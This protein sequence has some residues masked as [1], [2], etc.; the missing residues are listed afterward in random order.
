MVL[1][2]AS[3]FSQ[4]WNDATLKAALTLPVRRFRDSMR[5]S[6]VE[7]SPGVYAFDKPTSR[8]PALLD[9]S[10]ARL[11]LT[12]NW[13]NPH[14]DEGKTPHTAEALAAFGRFAAET[15]KR[16]PAVDTVEI[17]NEINGS[18]FVSGPVKDGG[19]V[20]RARYHL[21]MVRAARDAVRQVRPDVRVLGGATH[22]LP[23]GFLWNLLAAP[24]ADA[25]EG[26]AVHPYT[27]PIDQL[28]AQFAVLRRD[29]RTA[30]LPVHVTEFGS[31]NPQTAA[32]D[33]VRGYAVLS[34]L[35]VAEMDWYPL[36]ERGDGMVPLL[37]RDQSLTA[38]G[39]A[40]RFVQERLASR[41]ATSRNL[42][43]FT[44]L[45]AFG[46]NT[47][48]LW[49]APRVLTVGRDVTA[50]DATGSR[51]DSKALMINA[52]KVIILTS[53]SP[54]VAGGNVAFG[55]QDL[56]ADSFHQFDYAANDRSNGFERFI[57]IGGRALPFEVLPGQQRGGVPWT[58]YLGHTRFPRLRLHAETML[59]ALPQPDG[60]I[61]H[62]YIARRSQRLRL[63][64][65]FNA[66]DHGKGGIRVIVSQS[67][68]VLSDQTGSTEVRLD[69]TVTVAGGEALTIAVRGAPK[70]NAVEYRLKISD[71][72]KCQIQP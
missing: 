49:G 44:L 26:L 22:S 14:Y 58:P 9:A 39:L 24:G 54:L 11:T 48:V 66:P 1:G 29:R 19:L 55:C 62:R 69:E 36:N 70:G 17:G 46:P 8:Y 40:F 7:R 12:L 23:A 61:V 28:P 52:D 45:R 35:G 20:L 38:A 21:A 65:E 53:N 4:G 31:Q 50:Y 43:D 16:Y 72:A 3:N 59:P 37:R 71:V 56:I 60:A 67:G 15:V 33:L 25:V 34:A 32:D 30:G 57:Q 27:T 64:A 41:A 68:R 10:G 13:G 18:N 6:D 5:W 42:D 2:A 63:R 51:L 47:W